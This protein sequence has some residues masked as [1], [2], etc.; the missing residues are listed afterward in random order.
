VDRTGR[1][2]LDEVAAASCG[3]LPR[4]PKLIASSCCLKPLGSG[5]PRTTW[6]WMTVEFEGSEAP[7]SSQLYE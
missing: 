2:D 6:R 7:D 3:S 5:G 1:G 4:W